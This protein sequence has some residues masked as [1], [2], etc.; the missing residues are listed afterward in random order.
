MPLLYFNRIV[1]PLDINLGEEGASPEVVYL[2][3]D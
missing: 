1:A 3:W 2:L